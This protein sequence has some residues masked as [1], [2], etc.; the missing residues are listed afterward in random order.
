MISR[1]ELAGSFT[2]PGTSMI[3]NPMCFAKPL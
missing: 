3:V 1:T 2:M